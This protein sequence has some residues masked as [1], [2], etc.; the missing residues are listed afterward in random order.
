MKLNKII[1]ILILLLT[2]TC[3]K[4]KSTSPN[5]PEYI[6]RYESGLDDFSS[7]YNDDNDT[8]EVF[9][10]KEQRHI[11]I[12]RSSTEIIFYYDNEIVI[13]ERYNN[14]QEYFNRVKPKSVKMYFY[15][16]IDWKTID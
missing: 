10:E 1:L 12:P 14:Q 9:L 16:S 3:C 2:L 4:P 11:Y 7:D 5:D 8:Y 6:V 15:I 13:E